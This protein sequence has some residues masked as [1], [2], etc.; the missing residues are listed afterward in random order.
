MRGACAIRPKL[1]SRGDNMNKQIAITIILLLVALALWS[2]GSS[3]TDTSIG[4]PP[5]SGELTLL[6]CRVVDVGSETHV[7]W[8]TDAPSTAQLRYGQS[9]YTDLVNV[10]MS[11]D[12]HDVALAGLDY[13]TS[14]IFRLTARDA[15]GHTAETTGNFAT[16][17]RPPGPPIISGIEISTVTETSALVQWQTDVPA[18]TILYYGTTTATDSVINDSLVRTHRVALANLTPSTQY[19]LQFAAADSAGLRGLGRDTS[20]VTAQ[21]MTL[22]FADTTAELGDTIALSVRIAA[23]QDLAALRIGLQFAPGSIEVLGVDEGPFF[24]QQGGFVFFRDIRNSTGTVTTDMSWSINY[25]GSQRTGTEADGDGIVLY[26]RFRGLEPGSVQLT[27]A[28]DSS[29]GLDVFAVQRAC[30]LRAGNVNI[31]P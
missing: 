30:S 24:V 28:A 20:L 6:Y 17:Q 1:C 9:T 29:F 15:L 26:L 31:E 13:S 5:P 25:Q 14:Y 11:A 2:C 19:F 4:P 18:T 8:A 23:A 16:Q 3:G 7:Q 21:R 27:F 22:F 10:T 12:T